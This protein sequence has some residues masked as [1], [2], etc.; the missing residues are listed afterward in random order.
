MRFVIWPFLKVYLTLRI[1]VQAILNAW[2]LYLFIIGIC[3]PDSSG[4]SFSSSNEYNKPKCLS[5]MKDIYYR[6]QEDIPY[7]LS[8]TERLS[9]KVLV[10][11]ASSAS[12]EFCF[13]RHVEGAGIV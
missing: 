11:A 10:G 7:S 9:V 13:A 2:Q 4:N 3:G 8:P 12:H 5:Q 1:C 6:R